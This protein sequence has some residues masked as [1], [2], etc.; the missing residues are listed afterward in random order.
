MFGDGVG[1]VNTPFGE[2]DDGDEDD[3]NADG[4]DDAEHGF[5]WC[6]AADR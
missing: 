1:D 2:E 4:E 5:C 6:W 3:E